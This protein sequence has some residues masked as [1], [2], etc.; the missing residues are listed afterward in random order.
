VSA[1]THERG[2]AGRY[3]LALG[4]AFLVLL[5]AFGGASR[6]DE[7]QQF[8][9]R[10]SAIVAIAAAAWP[11]S[12]SLFRDARVPAAGAALIYLLVL[13][14]LVPLPP[15]VWSH[16]PGRAIYVDVAQR[17]GGLGWRPWTLSPDLTLNALGALLPATA[18]G[19]IA[20][21][22]NFRER[23]LLARLLVAIACASA[24]LGLMQFAAGGTVLHLFRTS[25]E[26]SAV[27]L[28]AN[29][30]H[31]AVLMACGLPLLGATAGIR[32]YEDA[33]S[34]R[35]S[36]IAVFAALLLLMGLASTG[37]RMGLLLGSLGLAAATTIYLM[38]ARQVRGSR[39]P[40]VAAGGFAVAALLPIALLVAR[41]G[42]LARLIADPVDQTRAAAWGP[43]VHAARM[44]FPFGS[45]F[46]TFE[47][48]YRMVEPDSL[49]STIYLN[50][51]HNE[52]LQL[53]I[54]GG[55]PALVLLVLFLGWWALAVARAVRPRESNPRRA[56]AMAMAAATLIMMLSSL[57][58]YPLRTP[59]LSALFAL[60]CVELV[61]ARR[62]SDAARGQ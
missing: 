29:R 52:P 61:R 44:F 30:N 13:V 10:L 34:K 53:A 16:M 48:V 9:V 39:R 50:Q 57:V 35:H 38:T 17:T 47:P 36:G 1:D 19:L 18:M 49:L 37:S 31:Q 20:L 40:W 56:L 58:D 14:Q 51:A 41:S 23:V 46:G 5:A 8:F 6:A 62:H 22:L 32:T 2:L 25:S 55:L 54:E 12:S 27:G 59:L 60:A 15:A 4:A 3:Y 43:M 26:D 7:L 24:L 45:G 42:A 11:P 33:Y 28:F 21:A